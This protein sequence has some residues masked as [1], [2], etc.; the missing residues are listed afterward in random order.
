[1]QRRFGGSGV[2]TTTVIPD[3]AIRHSERSEESLFDLHV[4]EV[5][6]DEENDD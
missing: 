1:L 6:S 4:A 3:K 5:A 2:G